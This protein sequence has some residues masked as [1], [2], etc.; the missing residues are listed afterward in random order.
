MAAT[1]YCW[2]LDGVIVGCPVRRVSPPCGYRWT[3]S[4]R[5][6]T[7][8]GRR[9]TTSPRRCT[10]R[11][12]WPSTR[13]DWSPSCGRSR[14][15]RRAAS[16]STAPPA[17]TGLLHQD[18]SQTRGISLAPTA[19]VGI[20]SDADVLPKGA[21]SHFRIAAGSATTVVVRCLPGE[22]CMPCGECCCTPFPRPW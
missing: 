2:R 10:S 20:E 21:G 8:T 12:C 9:S 1:N 5:R 15:P 14:T 3:R 18:Q 19:R 7:S 13:S 22:P 4:G 6:S 17:R 16:C 11:R